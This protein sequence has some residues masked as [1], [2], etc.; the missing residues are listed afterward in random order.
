MFLADY[1]THT[2]YSFDGREEPERIC[3][4]AIENGMTAI[5]I[6]DHY[7]CDFDEFGTAMTFDI[8]K[9]R[10]ELNAIK[11]RYKGRL[12]VAYGVEL[13]QPHSRPDIARDV[14][15]RGEFDFVIGSLHNIRKLPDFY[16]FDYTKVKGDILRTLIKRSLSELC[17]IAAF[18]GIDT[19]AHI[20]YIHRYVRAAGGDI[21]FKEYYDDFDNLYKI[22]I[23]NRV[24]L[25]INT[26]TLWKGYGFSM[27]NEELLRL[28]YECGGRLITVGSDA[29]S[30]ENVGGC[31]E[32][33]YGMLKK[34]G[35]KAVTA[36]IDGEK[37]LVKI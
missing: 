30:G 6:T 23:K 3:E 2:R 15:E 26:S 31:I 11:E 12:N 28:Y 18:S 1:H 25:E 19:L 32:E 14:L 20:T 8:K 37:T 7:E 4:K 33:A 36:V 17:E 34:I 10:E 29:H 22:L 9:R 35:F 24:S 16:Y 13:G 27:P 21:S 5:A